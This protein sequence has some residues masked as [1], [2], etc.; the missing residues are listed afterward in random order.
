MKKGGIAEFEVIDLMEWFM[1]SMIDVLSAIDQVLK[2]DLKPIP[3][4]KPH[5]KVQSDQEWPRMQ[6]LKQLFVDIVKPIEQ[7]VADFYPLPPYQVMR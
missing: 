1:K 5:S 2:P 6:T 4:N 7:L 3:T